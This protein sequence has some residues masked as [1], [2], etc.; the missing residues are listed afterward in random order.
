MNGAPAIDPT[1]SIVRL[2]DNFLSC[3]LI[4]PKSRLESNFFQFRYT[5]DFSVDVKDTSGVPRFVLAVLQ[6]AYGVR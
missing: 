4:A 2:L 1:F 5:F 3:L 6:V